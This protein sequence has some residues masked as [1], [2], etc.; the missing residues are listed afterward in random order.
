MWL[1]WYGK[2]KPAIFLFLITLALVALWFK[3]HA[4]SELNIEL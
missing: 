4:T 2:R 1:G 3:H